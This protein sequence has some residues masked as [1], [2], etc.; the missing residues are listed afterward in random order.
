MKCQE[1]NADVL[2]LD[3][4][5]LNDCCGLTLQ[6]YAIR[7]HMPLDLL[8]HESMVNV[9]DDIADYSLPS[10]DPSKRA[11]SIL[12]ALQLCG[13]FEEENSFIT[14]SSEIRR[15]DELLWY[16]RELQVYGFQYRQEY[17]YT[18]TSHRVVTN[19]LIK[20]PTAYLHKLT[21]N[22]DELDFE[23]FLAVLI[24]QAGEF[25]NGYIF[26]CLPNC[27][28]I[29]FL[30]THLTSDYQIRWKKLDGEFE[31]Q[32]SLFRTESLEDAQRLLVLI[33]LHLKDIPCVSER[34][35]SD[36]QHAVV[37]KELVFDSAHFI[38][39]HP[40]KCENLHGGRY[41]LHVKIEGR[42]DPLTGFVVDYGYLKEIVKKH[43]IERLDHQ[44]LN[45]VCADLG[46]RSSTEL[47]NIF[48][49]EQL[50]EFLPGLVE[51]Q[52]YETT[53]SFCQYRGPS[54]EDMQKNNG[55]TPLKHFSQP[56]L[57][58]S[59][60]RQLLRRHQNTKSLKVIAK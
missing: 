4:N 30:L 47:L 26:I 54:L 13:V 7:H 31:K 29:D 57:G 60:L 53:Q 44:N 46:W 55:K 2:H 32:T 11:L 15:L 14:L 10:G 58:R 34:Y 49:W 6:E 12:K 3:N 1:C 33:S 23:L 38:T 8:V 52:T 50:I 21:S 45:F 36:V 25:H 27:D 28:E 16:L 59:V 24:A 40:G 48:I 39:D 22:D 5:H 19:N 56:E 35:F 17:T 43:V 41:T 42:I 9:V 37:S 51:L 20:T 18:S